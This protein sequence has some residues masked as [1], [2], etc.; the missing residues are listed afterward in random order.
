MPLFGAT[1]DNPR[2]IAKQADEFLKKVYE[3]ARANSPAEDQVVDV[4]KFCQ[5]W[6]DKHPDPK[7][8]GQHYDN[9]AEH[10]GYDGFNVWIN[11]IDPFF[12]AQT[13]ADPEDPDDEF[14]FGF[15]NT[16]R[17]AKIFEVAQGTGLIGRL[18][19][20]KGFTHIDGVDASEKLCQMAR[21]SGWY[22]EITHQYLANG[23]NKLPTK[24]LGQYD[25]VFASG[26]FSKGHIQN[27]AGFNDVWAIMKVGGYFVTAF[28]TKYLE[29]DDE[30][31]Y[32]AKL[33]GF[34]DQGRLEV[35]KTMTF[36]R[37]N[38]DNPYPFFQE[39]PYMLVVFRKLA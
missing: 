28:R 15:L 24:W 23:V 3:D 11:F 10:V 5:M 6:V 38:N 7:T 14:N 9:I 20:E 1:P 22:R 35:V 36:M 29:D 32:K 21:E 13:V 27:P 18:L 37:G 31:G 26:C 2:Q 39:M 8:V 12:I 4:D 33:E 17:D 34:R 25:V 19:N 30:L 16:P